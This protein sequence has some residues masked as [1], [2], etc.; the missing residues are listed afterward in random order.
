MSWHPCDAEW[1]LTK[2]NVGQTLAVRSTVNSP[3]LLKSQA[4]P[5]SLQVF[6]RGESATK[7]V[8]KLDTDKLWG[9]EI[10]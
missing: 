9:D 6:L 8:I 7:I 1:V 10:S 2:R 5:E 4:I 3:H